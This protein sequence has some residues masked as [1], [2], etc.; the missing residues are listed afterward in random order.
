MNKK[1]RKSMTEKMTEVI[2]VIAN[3]S[4]SELALSNSGQV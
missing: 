3:G 2:S 1:R 4:V